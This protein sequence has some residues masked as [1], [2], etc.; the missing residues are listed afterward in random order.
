M[1]SLTGLVKVFHLSTRR[2]GA[3]LLYVAPDGALRSRV[4][5][6]YFENPSFVT[7]SSLEVLRIQRTF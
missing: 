7:A 1:S 4:I 5:L 2:S 6:C 3:G